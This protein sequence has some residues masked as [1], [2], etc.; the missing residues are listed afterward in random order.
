MLNKGKKFVVIGIVAV[1]AVLALLLGVV[2]TQCGG[3]SSA[4]ETA[5]AATI[6]E[7]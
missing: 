1:V 4:A 3:N 7:A 5:S 2:L 6:V